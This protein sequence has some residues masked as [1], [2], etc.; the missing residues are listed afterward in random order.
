MTITMLRRKI[1][2]LNR[3][4]YL[5]LFLFLFLLEVLVM[6][7]M[8][9]F[10]IAEEHVWQRALWDAT[11]V[12]WIA[13]PALCFSLR[14]EKISRPQVGLAA[15]KSAAIIFSSES[16]LML[17]LSIA[18]FSI[19][20]WQETLLDGFIFSA[21]ASSAIYFWVLKPLLNKE[22]DPRSSISNRSSIWLTVLISFSVFSFD[23]SLPLG[24][25]GGVPYIALVLVGLWFPH[26]N[27]AIVLAAI[28]ST[29]TL[30][31]YYASEPMAASW[32]VLSN[33]GLALFA[34]W[35]TAILVTSQKRD[36]EK[37]RLLHVAAK[38]ANAIQSTNKTLQTVLADVCAYTGWPI[39][40]V[41]LLAPDSQDQL[42][43]ADAWS[44]KEGESFTPFVTATMNTSFDKGAGL[45][46]RVLASGQSEWIENVTTDPNFPRAEVAAEAGIKAACAVPIFAGRDIIAVMEFFSRKAAE[47]DI[48]MLYLLEDIGG[49][50]GRVFEREKAAQQLRHMAHRDSLTGLPN[51]GLGQDRLSGA[52]AMARRNSTKTALMFIDLDDFKSVNDTLGHNAGDQVL[53]EVSARLTSCVREADTVARIGGDEFIII[54]TT[55][56]HKEGTERV[57]HKVI[58]AVN[59]PFKLQEHHVSIGASIGIA[60]YPD[61]GEESGILMTRADNAMYLVKAEGKNNY[62]FASE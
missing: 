36:M 30:I 43:P 2:V 54:L 48:D 58:D 50:L 9:L 32:A 56:D 55:I 18:P 34:I 20:G 13:V 60:I 42:L 31:G 12:A 16:A 14:R 52:I 23:I 3:S 41:Y 26:R 7:A 11:A 22:Y 46:G 25:A 4:T 51:L 47:P 57:A 21:I 53:K 6:L 37:L 33:R 35:L 19:A 27:A 15:V 44:F 8:G 28:G 49:Q 1:L 59:A 29:L 40:H 62:A 61:H 17:L 45:P 24:V 39:G 5:G 10:H 38:N